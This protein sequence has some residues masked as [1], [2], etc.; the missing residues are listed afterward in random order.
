M[1]PTFTKEQIGWLRVIVIALSLLLA[2]QP[3]NDVVDVQTCLNALNQEKFQVRYN[4]GA[5]LAVGTVHKGVFTYTLMGKDTIIVPSSCSEMIRHVCA[6]LNPS[7][8]SNVDPYNV[9]YLSRFG[10]NMAS[11]RSTLQVG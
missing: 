10:V 7:I 8:G 4:D 6:T 2:P 5:V 3:P 11:L 1:H 9:L